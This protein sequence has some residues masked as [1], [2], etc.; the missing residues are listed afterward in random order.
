M[1][2][3]TIYTFLKTVVPTTILVTLY[4]KLFFVNNTSCHIYKKKKIKKNCEVKVF[5]FHIT[6]NKTHKIKYKQKELQKYWP[7]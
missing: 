5:Y 1:A 4:C 7:S 3:V 6:G 2:N